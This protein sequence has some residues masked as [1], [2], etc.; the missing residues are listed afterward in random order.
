MARGKSSNSVKSKGGYG[1]LKHMWEKD[2]ELVTFPAETLI[3]IR[4]VGSLYVMARHWIRTSKR[5]AFPQWCTRFNSETEEFDKDWVCP[6]CADF[7]IGAPK[8]L[9]GTC[10]VR[11]IQKRGDNPVRVFV[12]PISVNSEFDNIIE[13][14]GVPI[15]DEEE[16]VNIGIKYRPKESGSKRW[17][18][19]HGKSAPLTDR[20]KKYNYPNLDPILPDFSDEEVQLSWADQISE[21]LTSNKYYI[22]QKTDDIPLEDPWKA[23]GIRKNGEPWTRFPDLVLFEQQIDPQQQ[24]GGTPKSSTSMK[25]PTIDRR[26]PAQSSYKTSSSGLEDLMDDNDEEDVSSSPA[27]QTPKKKIY[28]KPKCYGKY[29]G[30][31]KCLQKCP[32]PIRKKCQQEGAN[33]I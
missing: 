5:K 29:D 10:I 15:E 11:S 20:E 19:V 31:A 25:K 17:G 3:Q 9:I 12:L 7:N 22:E 14:L 16:G 8:Y 1:E 30:S 27:V 4:I 23:F 18:V 2:V 21:V 26:T 32:P 13:M 28:K 6:A 33:P 24:K